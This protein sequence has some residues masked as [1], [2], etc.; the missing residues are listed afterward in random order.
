MRHGLDDHRRVRRLHEG[1][2]D[3]A[4]LRTGRHDGHCRR[5]YQRRRQLLRRQRLTRREEPDDD[6]GCASHGSPPHG[7]ITKYP[8][9]TYA[10]QSGAPVLLTHTCSAWTPM[11]VAPGVHLYCRDALQSC[12]IVHVAVSK[13]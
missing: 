6:D 8:V 5:R 9:P 13:S 12:T 3:P 10:S 7:T 11:S 1:E 2:S 4:L